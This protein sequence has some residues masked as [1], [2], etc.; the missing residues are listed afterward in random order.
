MSET[1]AKMGTIGWVD[2]T[3]EN[4]DQVRDFY[5]SVVGWSTTDTDMGGYC[6]YTMQAEGGDGIAGVCHARGSNEGLP[7]QWLMY[8]NVPDL[9]TSLEKC[10]TKGGKVLAGPKGFAGQGRYAVI[11]DPAGAVM[12]IYQPDNL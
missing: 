7:A 5:K 2:L 8:V 4:A 10:K 12:A 3:V 6:D 11:Q 9:D 1:K